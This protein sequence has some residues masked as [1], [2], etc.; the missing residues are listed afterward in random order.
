MLVEDGRHVPLLLCSFLT[1][2]PRINGA[3]TYAY[4]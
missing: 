1:V 4:R 3:N 2:S